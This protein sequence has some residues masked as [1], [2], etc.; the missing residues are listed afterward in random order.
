V[1][2]VA[3]AVG[4]LATV[5]F[6]EQTRRTA[7]DYTFDG[8]RLGANLRTDVMSK[9]AYATPCDSDPIE[10]RKRT[11][12]VYMGQECRGQTFPDNTTVLFYLPFAEGDASL[13]Q[14]IQAMAWMGGSYFDSR[15]DF[16]ARVGQRPAQVDSALGR[17]TST[18]RLGGRRRFVTVREHTGDVFSVVYERRVVAFVVG[19]MP[20]NHE[21]ES[22][23]GLLEMIGESM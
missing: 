17:P 5:A 19:Q 13:A 14:P 2:A 10:G 22:W 3:V 9:A 8:F 20:D 21:A 6:A 15:S 4:L 18:F 11:I 7:T 16:P 12:V 1:A 23:E